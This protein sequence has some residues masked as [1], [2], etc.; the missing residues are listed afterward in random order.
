MDNIKNNKDNKAWG[1]SRNKKQ[2]DHRCLDLDTQLSA[3]E[4]TGIQ[5][6][7]RLKIPRVVQKQVT[8]RSF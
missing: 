8:L 4:S 5:N 7:E 2:Y 6:M 1:G 3:S